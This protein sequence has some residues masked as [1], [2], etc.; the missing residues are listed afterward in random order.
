[1]DKRDNMREMP[2]H[3]KDHQMLMIEELSKISK[4]SGTSESWECDNFDLIKKC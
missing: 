1:M 2:K 3:I 4:L